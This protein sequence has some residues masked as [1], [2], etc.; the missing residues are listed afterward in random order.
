[1]IIETKQL[2]IDSQININ[3]LPT[4][5]ENDLKTRQKIKLL[6]DYGKA[7]S[8]IQD[9]MYAHNKYGVLVCIQGMDTA[10]KDSLIREV[11]RY[12]NP[13]GV[14]VHSFKTP[15]SKELQHDYLWR[16]YKALPEKGKFSIFNRSHYEN[17]LITKVNPHFLLNENL[18][19]VNSVDD[20]TEEFWDKRFCQIINFEEHLA[21]N[22]IIVIKIFLHLSKDEQKRRILRRLKK[23]KHNWKFDPSDISERQKWEEYQQYYE[24]IFNKTSKSHA[25]WFV[26]PADDKDLARTIVAKIILDKMAQY[27]DIK[28]PELDDKIKENI[29]NYIKQ[30]KNE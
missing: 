29:D 30:L 20:V 15:T 17:L 16:H 5:I 10:G 19:N 1:M 11:F 21:D 3:E 12:F 9:K 28:E 25:P 22:G 18:H 2:E 26:V 27:N 7:L 24:D 4:L 14:N 23:Q 13:R 6:K 8:V